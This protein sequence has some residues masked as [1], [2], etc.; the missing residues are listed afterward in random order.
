MTVRSLP[1]AITVAFALPWAFAQ[2]TPEP[3]A[4]KAA[5]D[6]PKP[7]GAA[8]DKKPVVRETPP[9]VKAFNEIG[10]ITDPEKKISA[11]EK[12]KTDFPTS[13]MAEA[14]DFGALST[15][16]QKLPDQKGRI[17][18]TA[19]TIYHKAKPKDRGSMAT[20]IADQYL[21][22]GI[23]LKDAESYAR[24]GVDSMS[25]AVYMQD[26]L[27]SY[28]KRKQKPP[29]S[30][31]LQKRFAQSRAGRIATLGRIEVQ[32]G[33]VKKGQ[34][35]LE[36]SFAVNSDNPAVASTLGELAFKA[37]NDSKA[38]EYLIPARLSG[39]STKAANEALES[40]YRKTHAG[41]DEDV[42]TGLEA[43]LDSEYHK[44]YP[45]PVHVE[46]YQ[47][48]EKRGDRVV[49][50]E[51]FTGSGCPPCAGADVAFDAAMERYTRKDLAVIMYHLH[52]PRPDP[53]TDP[54]TQAR[55]KYYEVNGV[56]SYVIDGNKNSGGGPRE[57][58]K[59]TY[60]RFNKDIEKDLE[61]PA[62]AH[63][64]VGAHAEGNLVRVRVVVNGIESESKDLMLQMALVEKELRF[65]GENGI[66]FHPMVVRAMGGEKGEGFA[67]SASGGTFEHS[68]RLDEISKA[69]KDHLDD[70][71][72]KGHRGESF[73]FA[74]KKYQINPNGL[75]VAVFVEDHK[76]KHIL[77][78]SFVDLS[79]ETSHPIT[80][81]APQTKANQH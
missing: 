62:E 76:T 67:V 52:I 71:E 36:E 26:Q 57:M 50:A 13:S 37:G 53:M 6:Q 7:E 70:Y 68:F 35:L 24:K 20:R 64:T 4:A 46:A 38:L 17:R 25:L 31:E 75:A 69:I 3:Q 2:T 58:A 23:L 28:E 5:A 55:G 43:M 1:A 12:F 74:E 66:R 27:A 81:E 77:Q 72:A 73:K 30:E 45:N 56:P 16:V 80:S 51:V 78:A 41:S 18:S 40:V 60:D 59:Q 14:A 10:K 79:S 65:N 42:K 61:S 48:T 47:P 63:F 11:Y 9:D 49:L 54:D 21:G 44:R 39:R 34:K 33:Q 15:L 29:S 19:S 22:S 32:L 8:P